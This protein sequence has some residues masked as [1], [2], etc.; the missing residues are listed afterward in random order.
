MNKAWC[1]L[2]TLW[3]LAATAQIQLV[4]DSNTQAV[5]AGCT[6]TVKVVLRNPGDESVARDVEIR[7]FQLAAAGAVPIGDARLWKRINILPRQTVLENTTV[8]L[9]EVRAATGFGIEL[10]GIG[11]VRVTAWPHDLLQRLKTLAG[12][13]PLGVFD[14][15]GQLKPP[16]KQAS[17]TMADFEIEPTDSKLAIVWSNGRNLPESVE[18]RVKKGM[19]AVWIRSSAVPTSYAVRLGAGVVVVAPETTFRGLADSPLPQLTLIRDAELALQ[20]D[21]LRLPSDNQTE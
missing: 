13:V 9:P 11:R 7:L 21:A 8:T 20:P 2:A 18:S 5:F 3:P 6:Q 19:S 4:A 10:V 17:V 1:L 15:D 12:D 16:L 14:P